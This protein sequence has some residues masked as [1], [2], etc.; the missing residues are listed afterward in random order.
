MQSAQIT[1]PLKL[2]T[3]T[4]RVK[5]C[6]SQRN[7]SQFQQVKS[8]FDGTAIL[9]R[10][11]SST[12]EFLFDERSCFSTDALNYA[13][14]SYLSAWC[15]LNTTIIFL[16]ERQP[17]LYYNDH[18]GFQLFDMAG[19]PES[20]FCRIWEGRSSDISDELLQLLETSLELEIDLQV[21]GS[22]CE[23]AFDLLWTDI[24]LRIIL[25]GSYL[26]VGFLNGV[27]FNQ[28]IF[29]NARNGKITVTVL[30]VNCLT[31][32]TLGAV[33]LTAG[34]RT[35]TDFSVTLNNVF[36]PI[37]TGSSTATDYLLACR[38]SEIK[39]EKFSGFHTDTLALKLWRYRIFVFAL[40]MISVDWSMMFTLP[41]LNNDLFVTLRFCY[42]S[43]FIF[44]QLLVTCYLVY[45]VSG[46]MVMFK[47]MVYHLE[48]RSSSNEETK[49]ALLKAQKH[50]LEKIKFWVL[51]SVCSSLLTVLGFLLIAI[52]VYS[53]TCQA[54]IIV[55][56][57]LFIGKLGSVVA[58][59]IV[60]KPPLR[61][62]QVEVDTYTN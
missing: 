2:F 49:Q 39:S 7:L 41:F 42:T 1:M 31:M 62:S 9:V 51:V 35:G 18:D 60:C 34:W 58:Q 44:L 26:Y 38:W 20:A 13:D 40:G 36:L 37:F 15:K 48:T 11:E 52:D 53:Q 22:P 33:L 59:T 21:S 12:R 29:R 17:G 6:D 23:E 50:V 61:S 28:G 3:E 24:W 4:D 46:M 47:N 14:F 8:E 5:L 30:V 27:Y 10:V 54:W 57:V 45:Q 25:G 16:T 55:W 43:V 32:T 19:T 56:S